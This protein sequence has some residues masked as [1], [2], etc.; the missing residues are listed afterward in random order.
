MGNVCARRGHRVSCGVSALQWRE[1][2]AAR[3][4]TAESL[5]IA[6]ATLLTE[7][8]PELVAASE[9]QGP[10]RHVHLLTYGPMSKRFGDVIVSAGIENGQVGVVSFEVRNIGRGPGA[11]TRLR[12]MSLDT[13]PEG[14][15]PMYWEPDPSFRVRIVVPAEGIAPADLVLTTDMPAWFRRTRPLAR[16]SGRA[17]APRAALLQRPHR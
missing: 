10:E 15:G 4:A 7:Q 13:L 1:A 16:P 8:R 6:Q 3:D 17:T 9:H 11:I 2:R 12:V 5:R 14:G